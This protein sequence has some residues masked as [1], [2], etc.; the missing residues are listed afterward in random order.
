MNTIEFE[1]IECVIGIDSALSKTGVAR[2]GHDGE[3]CRAE[4][5]VIATPPPTD[6]DSTILAY[7]RIMT[8]AARI[9]ALI[10]DTIPVRMGILEAPAYDAETAG[11]AWQ[12]AGLWWLLI[13]IFVA[14]DI[15]FATIVPATLKKW[16]TNN[17]RADKHRMVEAMHTMWPGVPCTAHPQMHNECDALAL[18][19]VCAQR[20]KWP[21]PVRGHQPNS[22]A[23]IRWP[24]MAA[25]V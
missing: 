25:V 11:K 21:V 17:G 23:V 9:D 10:P 19:T 13:G 5:F 24:E 18:S 7:K 4:T 14:H 22:L 8:I 15:P 12:R 16:A 6:G 3:K 2:I 1:P 20:L